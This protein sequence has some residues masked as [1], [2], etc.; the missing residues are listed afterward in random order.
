MSS[1]EWIFR[2]PDPPAQQSS[3]CLSALSLATKH[4]APDILSH[5]LMVLQSTMEH[6]WNLIKEK[7]TLL[8]PML[9]KITTQMESIGIKMKIVWVLVQSLFLKCCV[10]FQDV[11]VHCVAHRSDIVSAV[12]L[13]AWQRCCP[14]CI[15]IVGK[16]LHLSPTVAWPWLLHCLAVAHIEKLITAWEFF[17]QVQGTSFAQKQ[18]CTDSC[19]TGWLCS[20]A[21]QLISV[22][23]NCHM[24]ICLPSS[25]FKPD[26]LHLWNISHKQHS[27]EK[28]RQCPSE[29]WWQEHFWKHFDRLSW[30]EETIVFFVHWQWKRNAC[31][32]RG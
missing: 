2:D 12:Q 5:N 24:A 8:C 9:I 22:T 14:N 28:H 27:F 3:W 10:L 16:H 17:V 15:Q 31:L 25:S 6:P 29:K 19:C 20:D 1:P 11:A 18:N 32:R 13:C 23:I 21:N 4:H 7:S 30:Q 26:H